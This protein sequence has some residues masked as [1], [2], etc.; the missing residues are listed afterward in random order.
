PMT[1]VNGESRF[2]SMLTKQGIGEARE[3]VKQRLTAN[4]FA[5]EGVGKS[6]G[7]IVRCRAWRLYRISPWPVGRCPPGPAGRGLSLRSVSDRQ[8]G[9]GWGNGPIAASQPHPSI[10]AGIC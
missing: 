6:Y 9:S 8:R 10:E 7:N 5:E 3:E 1:A 4:R 2:P